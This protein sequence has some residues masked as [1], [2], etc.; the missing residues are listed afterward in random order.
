[1]ITKPADNHHPIHELIKERWSPR[2]FAAKPVESEKLLSLLEAAR[3]AA[4]SMNEQP[5]HFIIATKDQGAEYEKLLNCLFEGNQAWA[6]QAPVLLLTVAKTFFARNDRENGSALHDLGLAMG[7]MALQAT[8]LGL[9]LHMMG[10]FDNDKARA[11]F[12]IPERFQ[13]VT[14]VAIGYLDKPDTLPDT[15]RDRELAPRTRRSLAE[16]VYSRQWAEV[17]ELVKE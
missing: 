4:S 13:P 3:W 7:N 14:L 17:A 15:L 11:T 6:A 12:N 2:A 9:Y 1:M 16:F 10:G 5:W 8:S